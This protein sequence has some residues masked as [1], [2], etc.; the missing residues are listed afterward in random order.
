LRSHT[1]GRAV[2]STDVAYDGHY[3]Q[4]FNGYKDDDVWSND[5]NEYC[6]GDA[7]KNYN[8]VIGHDSTD[9]VNDSR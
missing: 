2:S 6:N 7:N 4:Y 3:T 9:Y 8:F 1:Y 5:N